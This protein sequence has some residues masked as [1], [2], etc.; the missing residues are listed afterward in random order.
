MSIV[1]RPL[2]WRLLGVYSG[3]KNPTDGFEAQ[4]GLVWRENLIFETLA[5]KKA[6]SVRL[7]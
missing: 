4:I 3:R 6:A 2:S 7:T 1:E 5:A